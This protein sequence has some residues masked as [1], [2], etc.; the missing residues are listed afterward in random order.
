[1][2]IGTLSETAA[3]LT[4]PQGSLAVQLQAGPQVVKAVIIVPSLVEERKACH[5]A[6]AATGRHMAAQGAAVLRFDPRGCGDSPAAFADFSIPDWLADLCAAAQ[7]LRQAYPQVPQIWLGV[8]AGAL[9]ALR[10]A[11]VNDAVRPDALVLWEPVSGPD[12]I[13]Q[14]LQRRL[15][16]EMMAYGQARQGRRA[17]EQ[18][19]ADGGT[20]DFDGFPITAR[21]YRDLQELQPVPWDGPGLIVSTGADTQTADT[22]H[23]LAP[24][25]TRLNLRL[26]PFWN[27]VGHVDTRAV[28]DATVAWIGNLRTEDGRRTTDHGCPPSTF[29]GSTFDILRFPEGA[30][31][32]KATPD[33]SER[34]VAFAGAHGT[35]RGVLH[36]PPGAAPRRGR[37][38]FLHGWSGDRS[39]PHRMFVHAARLL[40]SQGYTS[41]R[42]DF[43]GRGD[44]DSLP[45]GDATIATMLA[46][47]RAALAWLRQEVPDDGPIALLAIC[48]G[49]KVAISVAAAEPDV[50]RLALWSAE[51]MGS[52]RASTTGSRKRLAMLRTYARKLLDPETWRKLLRGQVHAGLVG[53]ALVQAEVRSSAEARAEDE[54]LRAFRK[55][56]GDI[57]FIFGG[58][59]PE[60]AG[61]APA[62]AR[63]CRTH[64]IASTC[65][66]VP[67]AGHSFYGLTW[68]QE[69]LR[70]TETWLESRPK[71]EGGLAPATQHQPLN[72]R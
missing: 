6:L 45:S 65:H 72:P 39:G 25:T 19:L 46:D 20:V 14:L 29:C 16:N 70:V 35:V 51:S 50:A 68:E 57:L 41:L 53:K 23:G 60:T 32:S 10:Q 11:S 59:D 63:Y 37:I 2:A 66:T 55:F 40:A 36:Q 15:V 4:T 3:F 67:H 52:L 31:L 42:F 58:S 22:C 30:P 48:S 28:T 18:Q 27:T 5:D 24:A 47:T 12:F 34:M 61:S 49:C 69:V 17:I 64:G 1:M 8:R 9:L 54:A 33:R 71:A 56:R 21:L 43:C 44:S 13:R 38:V 7:W 26:P 62:Y